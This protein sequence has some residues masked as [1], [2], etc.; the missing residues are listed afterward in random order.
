MTQTL[1]F[2][3]L[4]MG[5]AFVDLEQAVAYGFSDCDMNSDLLPPRL[6]RRMSHATRLALSAGERACLDAG[7]GL[8]SLP[9][10]FAS[11]AGEIKITDVLCRAI[12]E[13]NLPVSPTQF[14]NSVHN[15]AAGYWSIA[16]NN[17]HESQ[18][19]GAGENTLIMG[20]LESVCQ[21]QV[22]ANKVLLICY[23]EQT[24]EPLLKDRQLSDCAVA[25]VLGKPMTSETHIKVFQHDA[26]L[27]LHNHSG[28][29]MEK[30]LAFA[31]M[32][33]NKDSSVSVPLSQF[34][35]RWL[36]ELA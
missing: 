5:V 6:R 19:I 14:H 3:V 17:R 9:S 33:R 11:I 1:N 8:D 13:H 35:E 28:S 16:T 27:E 22:T 10:V 31:A 36:A 30:A 20:L 18:A 26:E 21:L 25:F 2:S 34:D 7:V 4:G 12:A 24:P 29:V 23:D 15:T 32:V